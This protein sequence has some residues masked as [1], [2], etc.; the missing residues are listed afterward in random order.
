MACSAV[1]LILDT[2]SDS[3]AIFL[4]PIKYL[5]STFLNGNLIGRKEHWGSNEGGCHVHKISSKELKKGEN[6]LTVRGVTDVW[7]M[8]DSKR[9]MTSENI[10]RS[11]S[12][13]NYI[14]GQLEI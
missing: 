4:G 9:V 3:L 10:G 13:S 14:K 12:G 7:E 8:L 1:L 5:N 11:K 6:I 2:Y